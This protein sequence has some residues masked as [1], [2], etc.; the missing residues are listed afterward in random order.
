MKNE[1]PLKTLY[2]NTGIR[3]FALAILHGDNDHR[4]WL[5]EAAEAFITGKPMPAPRNK[6][7]VI[8]P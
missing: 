6:N 7:G 5:L 2:R 8:K 4:E 1:L 3:Q